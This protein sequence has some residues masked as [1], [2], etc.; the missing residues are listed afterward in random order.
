MKKAI[1]KLVDVY[2]IY[3]M[4]KVEVRALDGLSLEVKENEFVAIMGPSGSG[5]S[6]SVNLVG[7]LDL[8]T[9]GAVYL[10][11]RDISKLT[12][13]D[14]AKIRGEKIG[15]VFQRFNLIHTLS[16]MENVMLPMMFQGKPEE[17]RIKRAKHLLQ[18]VDLGDRLHHKPLEM[19]GGEQQR[20]AI[21][22]A[23]AN[24]PDV[25]IA[26]EPTGN[27]DSKTGAQVIDFLEKLHK[28]G[29]KTIIMVTHDEKLAKRAQKI[30]YLF[31]GR[32]IKTK[33]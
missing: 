7:C 29:G 2:K 10:D 6:T 13:S 19:S 17:A 12:E 24:D 31:D 9:K 23:L 8:P 4:G 3:K 33:I 22:R 11:G 26:D 30:A 15:F 28:K 1:I 32:I 27:L 14:L 5:K 25:L 20:V 18:M 21:A 16:A